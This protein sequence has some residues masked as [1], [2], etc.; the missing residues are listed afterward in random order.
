MNFLCRIQIFKF[1]KKTV[2]EH[3]G[4]KMKKCIEI[5]GKKNIFFFFQ[6]LIQGSA[7]RTFYFVLFADPETRI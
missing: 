4:L 1:F 3:N 5:Y 6:N 2:L 7:K